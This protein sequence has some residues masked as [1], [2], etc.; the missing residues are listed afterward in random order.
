MT[1]RRPSEAERSVEN[2]KDPGPRKGPPRRPLSLQAPKPPIKSSKPVTISTF[3][4][5]GEAVARRLKEQREARLAQR[6]LAENNAKATPKVTITRVRS[7]KPPTRP[8]FELPGEAIS[9]RKREAHEAKLKAQEEE[10]RK[11]REFKAKPLRTS[12]QPVTLPRNTAASL[13]R[14]SKIGIEGPDCLSIS[15][16][17]A[18]V[19]AHRLSIAQI[20]QAN[21]SAPRSPCSTIT[22][23]PTITHTST[24]R[25]VSGG[26]NSSLSGLPSQRAVTATDVQAQRQRAKEIYN[27]DQ[28]GTEDFEREKREREAAARLAREAAA[29]RGR[30]ASREWAEKQK[31]K[32][33]ASMGRAGMGERVKEM[34]VDRP[35]GPSIAIRD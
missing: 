5:P 29:E 7:N 4:L 32:K 8:S 35:Q 13:A 21:T 19:G 23:Q 31:L 27:R 16:S 26:S 14:R 11:K 18:N 2:T 3:E 28:R 34:L 20:A 1:F 25:K 22:R 15:K 17:G 10:G 12:L 30:Q 6:E 9:R 24:T 33:T